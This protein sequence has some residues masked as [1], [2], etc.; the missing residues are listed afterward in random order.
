MRIGKRIHFTTNHTNYTNN[1]IAK[2]LRI[3]FFTTDYMDNTDVGFMRI[4]VRR[5]FTTNDTKSAI[6]EFVR[7]V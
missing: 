4:C 3:M 5:W 7:F 6:T 2:D 1:A